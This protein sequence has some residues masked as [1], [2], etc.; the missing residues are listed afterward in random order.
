[1][2]PA[3]IVTGLFPA[4]LCGWLSAAGAAARD[5]VALTGEAALHTLFADRTFYGH[6]REGAAWMEYC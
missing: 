2:R 5:G 4:A 6:T 3:S 1:M